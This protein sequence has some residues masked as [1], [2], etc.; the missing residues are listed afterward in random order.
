MWFVQFQPWGA[1]SISQ[2][3]LSAQS[4]QSRHNTMSDW[5]TVKRRHQSLK[6]QSRSSV[7]CSQE[8][9]SRQGHIWWDAEWWEESISTKISCIWTFKTDKTAKTFKLTKHSKHSKLTKQ[10]KCSK[11]TKQAE[12]PKHLKL[13]NKTAKMFKTDKTDKISR[14]TKQPKHSKLTKQP[15]CLTIQV[16]HL[17]VQE[18]G[19]PLVVEKQARYQNDQHD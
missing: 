8:D 17:T 3:C 1:Q 19:E 11:L 2:R 7:T 18:K 16:G 15:K 10:P 4:E 9:H 6:V 12:Q 13:T 14:L 5:A